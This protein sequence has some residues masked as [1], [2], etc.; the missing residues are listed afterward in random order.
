MSSHLSSKKKTKSDKKVNK[1]CAV[2]S[3]RLKAKSEGKAY[4]LAFTAHLNCK[5]ECGKL[6]TDFVNRLLTA[7][8]TSEGGKS[9]V[10]V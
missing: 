2:S 8:P 6:S 5:P 7:L 1:N 10:L 9:C 4:A 3:P